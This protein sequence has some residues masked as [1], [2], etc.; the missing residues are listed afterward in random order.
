MSGGHINPSNLASPCVRDS[1]QEVGAKLDANLNA[2]GMGESICSKDNHHVVIANEDY[3]M[4]SDATKDRSRRICGISSN[5]RGG[6]VQPPVHGEFVNSRT[7]GGGKGILVNCRCRGSVG[8]EV[9]P[10]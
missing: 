5:R 1:S 7:N 6:G 8:V 3:L 2:T 4:T 10:A 9:S